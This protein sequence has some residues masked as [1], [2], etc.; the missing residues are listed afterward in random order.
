MGYAYLLGLKGV[1]DFKD[2]T[3]EKGVDINDEK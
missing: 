3:S 2:S 1:N